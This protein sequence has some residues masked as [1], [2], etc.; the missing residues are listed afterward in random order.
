[1]SRFVIRKIRENFIV[2]KIPSKAKNIELQAS[3]YWI[4]IPAGAE[5]VLTAYFLE[6]CIDEIGN[7]PNDI[8]STSG[9]INHNHN[10]Y[11]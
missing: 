6:F 4:H 5:L 11:H 8:T 3:F 7:P 9:A 10:Y 2:R 1:M